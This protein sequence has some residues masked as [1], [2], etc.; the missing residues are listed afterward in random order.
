VDAV[1]ALLPEEALYYFT[2]AGIPRAMPEEELAERARSFGHNGHAYP[3]IDEALKAALSK[4][5][6]EDLVLVCGSVFLAGE[7]DPDK[8]RDQP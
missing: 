1:L 3:N 5:G 7:L 6:S 2:R 8:Y 4:A